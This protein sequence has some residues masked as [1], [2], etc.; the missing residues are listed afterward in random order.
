MKPYVLKFHE[1]DEI[2][3]LLIGGKGKNLGECSKINGTLVPPGFCVTT[4]AYK[5]ALQAQAP[6]LALLQQLNSQTTSNLSMIREISMAIRALIEATPIPTNITEEI[7][8]ALLDFDANE[9]FAVRS[10]ATA[11]DLLTASFAGQHDTYLNIIGKSELFL[12]IKKCW[13]SLFTERAIIY[14]I[15]NDFDHSK[16]YLSVIIQKMV[17]PQA[18]GILFTADPITANRKSISIDA[19]FGLGEALVSGLVSAD[20]YKVQENKI[21][22]KIIATKKIAIYGLTDGGTETRQIDSIKQT[23]QTLTDEQILKLAKLGRKIE[24]HFGKP[25]DIEWCLVNND[26][27]IVQSR[28]ITTLFPIPEVSDQENHVYVSVAH[29][30]MM[31]DAMK[32]LGL[33]FYLM[34]TP[35][36]MYPAGGRLF[37]DITQSLSSPATRDIMVNSLG[38]SD[39][40]MKNALETIVDRENFIKMQTDANSN[41]PTAAPVKLASRNVP[42]PSVVSEL[43]TKNQAS[44]EKLKQTI[45]TKSGTELL[46][47]I[48]EDLQELKNVLF[49]PT[50]VD[51]IM[52]G[53][54]ASAWLN[55]HIN[56][57]LAEKN[58]ADT[59]SESAPNNITSQMGLELLDV[60][61]AIRP[62]PEVINYL[63]HTT[64]IH[65]LDNLNTL[66]GGKEA[67]KA[68]ETYLKKYGMRCPGEIDL[69]KTRWIENPTALIPLILSNIKNFEPHAS[70]KK[71]EQ[72]EAAARNKQQEILERLKQLPDG[73]QKAAETREKIAILR[74]FIGYREYPK[75]GM[76]NRYFI[77]KQALLKTAEQLVQNNIIKEQEDIYFLYFEELQEVV[78]TNKVDYDLIYKRKTDFASYEKLTPPRII[79]SDGEII[80]GKYHRGDIPEKALIGLP[81]SS[82]II[83][84]RARVILDIEHAD[85]EPGD[86]LVTAFTDPS[87]T[88]TFVSIKGLITEVGGLMTHGAVI[89][90]EYGLPAVVGVENATKLIKDGERIRVNGT[91]G[92]VE[93]L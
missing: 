29:Q 6:F 24:T 31:T 89:A 23:E 92:Y 44:L 62:N 70:K 33:S 58:V 83:E 53:M 1:I 72:G 30:Q 46:N 2:N 82:G 93:I 76:I 56:K 35:A 41:K 37:V 73:E 18:S 79:T 85:L 9:A 36:S 10:S 71:F 64:D 61:D 54:D 38:A 17:F 7:S 26:F 43:I 77:Y 52:A 4:E 15:Q 55:E 42:E 40:L 60:A 45:Q 28:P 22:E 27:Y 78:Q 63:E 86:I 20:A 51:A 12:H 91:E 13:A 32:P 67:R 8:Q 59:L 11:E 19:S 49:N 90:R 87:W 34:T 81:V 50:S 84:G 16:V 80:S 3:Q 68:I 75:Y 47:F 39:P 5:E 74:H 69:T 66:A 65:F 14:R 57:W 25:Q 48:A 21:T 88:P